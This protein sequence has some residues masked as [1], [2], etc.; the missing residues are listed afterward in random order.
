MTDNRRPSRRRVIQGLA[1]GALLTTVG[2]VPA[3]RALKPDYARPYS[4]KP[5]AA[6]RVSMDAVIRVI[7]GHR[8]YR[9][10]DDWAQA[11]L[12]LLRPAS[13]G[14]SAGLSHADLT[15]STG[16]MAYQGLTQS[17]CHM[18]GQARCST[19]QDAHAGGVLATGTEADAVLCGSCHEEVVAAGE[20]HSHHLAGK[21]GSACV[22]CH[23]P[24]L[25]EAQGTRLASHAIDVPLPVNN[26]QYDSVSR[27][28]GWQARFRWTIDPGN[29]LF[30]I[31][32]QNWID[33]PLMDRYFTQDRRGAAKFVYTYRW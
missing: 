29:D 14:L 24:P 13:R 10:G 11:F 3:T 25:I 33:D 4:R 5:W 26:V 27:R 7:V 18:E 9:P 20:A 2:C 8:P 21:P 30:V 31:Y 22:D 6:P 28:L 12:P 17:L 15:P 16:V 23:M 32:T 1:A 19:C